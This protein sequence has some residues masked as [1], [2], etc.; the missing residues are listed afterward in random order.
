[1]SRLSA[2]A[3]GDAC[4]CENLYALLSPCM[5]NAHFLCLDFT[6][7]AGVL[8][9]R[10]RS[11]FAPPPKQQVRQGHLHTKSDLNTSVYHVKLGRGYHVKCAIVFCSHSFTHLPNIADIQ[12]I[13]SISQ[14][15]MTCCPSR[16]QGQHDGSDQR[17]SGA[18]SKAKVAHLEAKK[19]EPKY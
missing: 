14:S 1:M 11:P 17:A 9:W 10:S 12:L 19:P 6:Q 15:S 4:M 7:C 3:G 5:P 2:T 13:R 8:D 16:D 18:G